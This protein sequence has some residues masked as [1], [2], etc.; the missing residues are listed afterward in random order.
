MNHHKVC[1][2]IFAYRHRRSPNAWFADYKF[3]H[4]GFFKDNLEPV[5]FNNTY[6]EFK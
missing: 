3:G 5:S 4:C 1:C 6:R 2:S